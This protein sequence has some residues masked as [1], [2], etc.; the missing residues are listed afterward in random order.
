MVDTISDSS[1][2]TGP[3]EPESTEHFE[4]V[5]QAS[6]QIVQDNVHDDANVQHE[7]DAECDVD[8]DP[9]AEGIEPD[10]PA[11]VV[12]QNAEGIELEQ[13]AEVVQPIREDVPW[14]V[15]FP[16]RSMFRDA[17][18]DNALPPLLALLR[19]P[20]NRLRP[21]RDL[22]NEALDKCA[23]DGNTFWGKYDVYTRRRSAA[24]AI[25]ALYFSVLNDY[26][27]GRSVAPL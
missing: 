9:N 11:E 18:V 3:V 4:Y 27:A 10:Q 12:Q 1:S 20:A 14:N 25:L 16:R 22:V 8:D 5:S 21:P 23:A 15:L 7:Q 19:E 6:G 2:E 24:D 13:P 26:A 17:I